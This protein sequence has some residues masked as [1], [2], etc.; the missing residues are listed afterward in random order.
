MSESRDEGS[1]EHLDHAE[2]QSG[3]SGGMAGGADPRA[4]HEARIAA[5]EASATDPEVPGADDYAERLAALEARIAALEGVQGG[6]QGGDQGEVSGATSREDR[7][8]ALEAAL[9]RLHERIGV[10]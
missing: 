7:L 3:V 8:D 9:R 2:G 4:D 10:A 6:D 5:L 1:G